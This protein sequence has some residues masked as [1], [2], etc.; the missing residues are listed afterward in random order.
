VCRARRRITSG[1]SV[2]NR[3]VP[4][5]P[6]QH[7]PSHVAILQRT[8]G[9]RGVIARRIALVVAVMFVLSPWD[10]WAVT[11]NGTRLSDT[12]HGT[13]GDDI[14]R[15]L[16]SRDLLYG[17]A[18]NDLLSG[19]TAADRLY[20]EDGDDELHGGSGNDRLEGGPGNDM[21]FGETGNDVLQ[22]G[23]GNDRLDGFDGDDILR[24]GGARGLERPANTN[25]G[26]RGATSPRFG[27]LIA[28][29]TSTTRLTRAPT[30]ATSPQGPRRGLT[31]APGAGRRPPRAGGTPARRDS[32]YLSATRDHHRRN[33][34]PRPH[35]RSRHPCP[36]PRAV[37]QV[38][39]SSAPKH[40]G[41][42]SGQ[43]DSRT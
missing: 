15:G 42:L 5:A 39:R 7:R 37:S 19:G 29:W 6:A 14:L 10:E 26:T 17:G 28:S 25:R 12:V 30:V 38:R 33:R 4:S 8:V 23:P 3:G 20:G 32:G 36:A 24:G 35:H 21:L 43:A 34:R 16:G 40:L 11:R 41:C 18:G 9:N 2:P 13:V 27:T 22:G 31:E 1:E